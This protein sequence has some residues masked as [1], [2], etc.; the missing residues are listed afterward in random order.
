MTNASLLIIHQGA[1]GDVVLT[2][3]AIIALRQKFCR[4]DIL[5]QGQLG[6]LAV[7]LGL[8]DKSY[9]LEA[10][11]FATL[12]SKP[13]DEKIK[14][15]MAGYT[16]IL[17]I[18]FSADLKRSLSQI[19]DSRCFLIPSRPPARVKIHVTEFLFKNLV[20]IGLFEAAD[21][22]DRIFTRQRKQIHGSG[23]PIDTSKII[24]HP[25]SG[26]IRK[27]WSLTNFLDLADRLEKRGLQ[28][29]F[30]GGPAEPDLIAE[31]RNHDQQIHT[32][33]EL[34]DLVDWL[35]S[36]GGYIG[37]DSGVSHLAAFLGIPSVVIFGPADPVRW[38]PLGPRVQIVHPELDCQPC[39]EMEPENCAQ[40]ECLANASTESVLSAFNQLYKW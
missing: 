16:T 26:S 11:Y 2:F 30:V 8:I 15:I 38:K 1:L 18:S 17:L 19:T 35:E 9:P 4:I 39:F 10:A 34:A 22:Y 14:N 25:G 12:F 37:N 5:C 6:N 21:S 27:R 36:A 32:F 7:K 23:G 28:P 31:I 13:V 29:T 20:E 3:P 33:S 40:P 24:I